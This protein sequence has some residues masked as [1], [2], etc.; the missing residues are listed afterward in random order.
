MLADQNHE[1]LCKAMPEAGKRTWFWLQV[2]LV[3]IAWL[4]LCWLHWDNDGLWYGDAPRHAANGLFWKD[5]LLNLSFDPKGYA[6]SYF[7]RYPVIAPT[8][9]PPMFYFLEAVFFGVLGPSPYIAKGLVLG[10]VLMAA[11]YTTAWCRRWIGENAGW[12]GVLFVL[13][14]GV[15]RWSHAIML[16]VPA[17]ALSIGALYHLRR[18]LESPPASPLWRHLYVGAALSVMSILTYLTSCVLLLIAGIWLIVERRWR[19]LWNRRT[20]VVFVVS[21]LALLPW[22]IVVI[23]FEP[24]RIVMATGTTEYFT[25]MLR[26]HLAYFLE[27]CEYYFKCLPE[28]FGTHL[29]FIAALGVVN[30]MLVR[31]LR[32]ET[33]LILIMAVVCFTFFAYV[34]AREGR[35]ILLLSVPIVCFCMLGLISTVHYFGKLIKMRTEWVRAATL[36]AI[37]V[38]IVGQAWVASK[39]SVLSISG[40]KQLVGFIEKVAPDE[41]VFYDGRS[42]NIFI[43]YLMAGDPD[44]HRRAVIGRKLIYAES[45]IHSLQEF[46]SSPQDAVEVLQKRGG[47]KWVAVNDRPDAPQIEAPWH[48]RKAV[49]GP[50][51][52]LVQSFPIT[53]KWTPDMVERNNVCVYRFLVP[54][55]RV[56]E[57]DMPLFSL[58]EN[59]R[60]RIKPIQ[61]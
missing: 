14:P 39:V 51:F 53:R 27:C 28:L 54:I 55:E 9:Y 48:L 45:I 4:F 5:Y 61:R 40:F 19:L 52:E 17:L 26:G 50:E 31:R 56:E 34:P 18:W 47:C 10:F 58:G 49:K 30:G 38:L 1:M 42:P 36:T 46:I 23:K 29:L 60:I 57:V 59:V 44:Y 25:N 43:F 6:L 2:L 21:A 22:V 33:I 24:K 15:I 7:A 8:S 12:A 32:H 16:N 3:F 13:L 11:L 41:P 37:A 35:Y 20:V